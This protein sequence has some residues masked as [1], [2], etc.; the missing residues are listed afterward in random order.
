MDSPMINIAGYSNMM[1]ATETDKMVLKN[2]FEILD[3]SVILLE[4]IE[5]DQS[6][7]PDGKKCAKYDELV[8]YFANRAFSLMTYRSFI[9]YSEVKDVN[10]SVQRTTHS[11]TATI[12]YDPEVK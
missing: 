12:R 6:T 7:L 8:K 1:M 5:C 3:H 11:I 2:S 9:D 10:E 4:V